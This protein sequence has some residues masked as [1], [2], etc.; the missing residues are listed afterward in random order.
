MK[1]WIFSAMG[2]CGSF[3]ANAFG[4]WDASIITLLIFMGIDFFTGVAVACIFHKST[5]TKTGA[6]NSKV[7][8][9]GLAKK[10]VTLL[11]IIIAVRLDIL[12]GSNYI[13]DAVC[14]AFIINEL[15]SIVENTGLMGVPIPGIIKKAIDILKEKEDKEQ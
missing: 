14:I 6:Y 4:G 2:V 8:F 3:I 11:F 7:G 9:K 1:S 5:K 10:G 15:L 12:I 13:R